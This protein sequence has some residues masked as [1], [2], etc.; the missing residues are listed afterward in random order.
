MKRKIIGSVIILYFVGIFTMM[1]LSFTNYN[2]IDRWY[3]KSQL[4]D[5]EH[6]MY[7]ILAAGAVTISLVVLIMAYSKSIDE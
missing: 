4:S 6:Q 5:Y 2:P 1:A 3:D 7:G